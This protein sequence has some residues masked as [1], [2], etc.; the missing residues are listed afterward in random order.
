MVSEEKAPLTAALQ[1][2]RE[3]MVFSSQDW[4]TAPDF[5]WLYGLLVG[6]DGDS[7]GELQV[8]FRWADKRVAEMRRLRAA[9]VEAAS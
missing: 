3:A 9:I 6:W 8:R 7:I 5:A 2:A 1:S 4:S